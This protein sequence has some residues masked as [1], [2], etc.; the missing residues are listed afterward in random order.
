M[1]VPR[2]SIDSAKGVL[3]ELNRAVER[4]RA[5]GPEVRITVRADSGFCRERIMARCESE[6]GIGYLF[7]LAR[8]PRLQRRTAEDLEAAKAACAESGAASRS[9]R[10]LRYRTLDSWSCERRVVGKAEWLPGPH[11]SNPRF[12]ATDIPA[13][14]PDARVLYEE[15]RISAVHAGRWRTGSRSAPRPLRRSNLRSRAAGQPAAGLLLGICGC[16][17][18]DHPPIRTDRHRARGGLSQ[19]P[20]AAS[21]SRSQARSA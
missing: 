18:R 11:D 8:N 1:R 19:G 15:L 4:I 6:E 20:S 5:R 9:F 3:R 10:E 21:C 7:G 14:E 13:E 12:T 2:S 16:R 17:D